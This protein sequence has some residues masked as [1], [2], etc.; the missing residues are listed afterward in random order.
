MLT[1]YREE[2]EAEIDAVEV[3]IRHIAMP[4]GKEKKKA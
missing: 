2:N 4:Y 1:I 3:L